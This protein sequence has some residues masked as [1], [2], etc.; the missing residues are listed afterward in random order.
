MD[1]NSP[2][3]LPSRPI[4]RPRDPA[5]VESILAA[6]WRLFLAH[7]VESVAV[8]TIAAEAGVAKAT[9]YA[10]FSD[11]RAMFQE[12][13]RREMAKIEAAKRL[14]DAAM[15][16]ATL[17]DVLITFGT[18]VMTFLTSPSAA[19]FYGSLSS[20]L[21]RDPELARMFY[22]AG[23]GRTLNNL[24]TIL[25]S[26]LA[27]ELAITDARVA[28]EMLIGMWQGITNYQL[29][30]G[31]DHDVVVESITSRVALGVDLFLKALSIQHN[32]NPS[33]D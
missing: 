17:R 14:D 32:E 23:P 26:P 24:S 13:V 8:D 27:S 16:G 15:A 7:G 6:S 25:A 9:V 10:Y 18:G 30:L 1:S 21:R 28:A 3:K 5:K 22:D 11:K 2:S 19:D 4:G 31:I 12:G 29:M 20:E 33:E